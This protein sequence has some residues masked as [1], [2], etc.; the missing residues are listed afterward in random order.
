MCLNPDHEMA[1]LLGVCISTELLTRLA[2]V[3]DVIPIIN[4]TFVMLISLLNVAFL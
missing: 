2:I 3:H 1:F 4:A